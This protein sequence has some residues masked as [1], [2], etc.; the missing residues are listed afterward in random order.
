MIG[1]TNRDDTNVSYTYDA[2][3]NLISATDEEGYTVT[4]TYDADGRQTAV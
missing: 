3:G 1:V 4:Y 2:N